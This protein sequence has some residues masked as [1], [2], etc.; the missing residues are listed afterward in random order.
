[1]KTKAIIA[2][3]VVLALLLFVVVFIQ[4][5]TPQAVTVRHIASVQSSNVTT[6]TFEITNH[7]ANTY[8]LERFD[9]ELRLGTSWT[10]V[11]ISNFVSW[12]FMMPRGVQ[13]YTF[14]LTDVK[15]TDLSAEP[16]VRAGVFAAS[17]LTGLR[18]LIKRLNLRFLH[19]G[20][21]VSLNPFAKNNFVYGEPTVFA[22]EEWVEAFK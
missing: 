5:N 9:V 16:V 19:K 1:V 20:S 11:S 10:D 6:M 8:I 4:R 7:T 21:G 15:L 13:S 12:I 18:G 2:G 14:K 22:S 3:A 17:N